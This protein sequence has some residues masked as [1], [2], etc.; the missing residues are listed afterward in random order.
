M[1]S[2]LLIA[3]AVLTLLSGQSCKKTS[4][5]TTVT[6]PPYVHDTS[7]LRTAVGTPI[8]DSVTKTIDAS[9][10]T[11]TSSDGVLQLT[12]PPGALS[13]PTVIGIQPVTNTIPKA[14]YSGYSL[15]PNG[16]QF[17]KPVTLVFH[18]KDEDVDTTDPAGM[19]VA[20]HPHFT[21]F[22]LLPDLRINPE[23]AY[24]QVGK[25]VHLNQQVHFDADP[26]ANNPAFVRYTS[27]WDNVADGPT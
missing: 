21:I 14:L 5:K 17:Q 6:P 4:S 20:Y 3:V 7:S 10:G 15:T 24:V 9:G 11:I 23:N 13:T 12:I 26:G 18:Y 16:Q 27:E 8:G 2:R 25:T 1:R 22:D 19:G